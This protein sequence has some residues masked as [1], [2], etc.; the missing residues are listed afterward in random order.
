MPVGARLN[1]P[2]PSGAREGGE[3]KASQ[4]QERGFPDPVKSQVVLIEYATY[5]YLNANPCRRTQASPLP[6]I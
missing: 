4:E 3:F 1:P 5:K 2:A 6:K